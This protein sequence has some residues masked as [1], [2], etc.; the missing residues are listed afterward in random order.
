VD[1][2]VI[3]AGEDCDEHG[4][5]SADDVAFTTSNT[6]MTSGSHPRRLA[7]TA[8]SPQGSCVVKSQAADPE[9]DDFMTVPRS[10]P[11]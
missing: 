10:R 8:R 5:R 4:S 3:H 2:N 1:Q 7:S 9:L 11:E 6:I